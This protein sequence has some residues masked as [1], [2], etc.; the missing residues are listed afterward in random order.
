MKEAKT[1]NP[2]YISHLRAHHVQKDLSA[3]MECMRDECTEKKQHECI[4]ALKLQMEFLVMNKELASMALSILSNLEVL[5]CRIGCQLLMLGYKMVEGMFT[6]IV[7]FLYKCVEMLY[8][9]VLGF[10]AIPVEALNSQEFVLIVKDLADILTNLVEFWFNVV[11][12]FL[13]LQTMLDYA[14]QEKEVWVT[15]LKL[16]DTLHELVRQVAALALKRAV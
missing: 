10:L 15:A 16:W 12:N 5:I 11:G 7:Y 8:T 13:H 9:A 2:C 4:Y 1:Y 6:S 14:A 3:L